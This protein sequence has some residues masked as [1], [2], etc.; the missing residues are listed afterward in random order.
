M[1]LVL[2]LKTVTFFSYFP[3][4]KQ[5]INI[6]FIIRNFDDEVDPK[7]YFVHLSPFM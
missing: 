6:Y 1:Q 4:S 7:N 5:I 3:Y 2:L